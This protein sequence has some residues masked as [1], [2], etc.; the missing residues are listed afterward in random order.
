MKAKVVTDVGTA[1]PYRMKARAAAAEH[2]AQRIAAAAFDVWREVGLDELTLQQVADRAGV[3]VQTVLRRFGSKD[4]V[5]QAGFEHGSKAVVM[6]RETA[7][8]GD[9]RGALDVLLDHYEEWG[10]ATLRTVALEDR[11]QAAAAIARF[12][13]V[14]H[15]DWCLRHLV[16]RH[17]VP[18]HI[19]PGRRVPS[20]ASAESDEWLLD[21]L[22]TATDA[23]VWKLLRRD[24]GRSRE[25]TLAVMERL[26]T[27]A[28][29][30]T[31][32]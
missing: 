11:F 31:Q 9:V 5:I 15:R 25:E 27:G 26:V 14:S 10:D 24:L 28:L 30:T 17:L 8:V 2:T 7:P 1:R 12:G 29:G 18:R 23:Y 3:T 16:P 4:G 13:R 21:A 6:Q 20:L 19:V 32:S 22:V